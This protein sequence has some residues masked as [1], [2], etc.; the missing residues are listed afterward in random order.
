MFINLLPHA[1]N[2][3]GLAIPP[4]GIVARCAEATLYQ[5]PIEG[6]PIVIKKYGAVTGLPDPVPGTW[7]IVSLLLRQACSDRED[8]LSPGDAV[9]DEAGRIVGCANLV[10][11]P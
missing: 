8:L 10:R 3:P 2:L 6:V 9:R 5:A 4:S 7:Y 1:I 11:N